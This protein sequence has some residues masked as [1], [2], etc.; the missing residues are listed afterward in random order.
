MRAWPDHGDDHAPAEVNLLKIQCE[1]AKVIEEVNGKLFEIGRTDGLDGCLNAAMIRKGSRV[2]IS[3]KT[4]QA[5]KAEIYKAF[6]LTYGTREVLV[7]MEGFSR[8]GQGEKFQVPG[9]FEGKG[10]LRA[11][12]PWP[13]LEFAI[14]NIVRMLRIERVSQ[15][16]KRLHR[17]DGLGPRMYDK[18]GEGR[19]G[20]LKGV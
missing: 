13:C 4:T 16:A 17:L 8:A 1:V 15:K 10:G 18:G 5:L 19:E 6:A 12:N 11:C 2:E 9:R 7:M 3:P 20:T 14:S